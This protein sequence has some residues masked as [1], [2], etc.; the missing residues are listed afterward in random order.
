M[1]FTIY[2]EY[3]LIISESLSHSIGFFPSQY[4]LHHIDELLSLVQLNRQLSPDLLEMPSS[5]HDPSK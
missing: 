1:L 4:P 5:P 3:S 2:R